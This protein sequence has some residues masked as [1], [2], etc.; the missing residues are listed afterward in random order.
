MLFDSV[1][2]I[3]SRRLSK[4]CTKQQ[5]Y[6]NAARNARTGLD[7]YEGFANAG[8]ANADFIDFWFEHAFL[9]NKSDM[10]V[11][12]PTLALTY[13]ASDLAGL[14]YIGKKFDN[15][16][17]RMHSNSGRFD[18]LLGLEYIRWRRKIRA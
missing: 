7:Y 16:I 15:P 2:V 10:T 8:F 18:P 1:D 17:M 12:D 9:V 11:V 5:C 4:S 14:S 13:K 6:A 3:S